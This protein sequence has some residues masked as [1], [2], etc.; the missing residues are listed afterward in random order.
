MS[1]PSVEPGSPRNEVARGEGPESARNVVAWREGV[2]G[3]GPEHKL[4]G[5]P[6]SGRVVTLIALFLS[7]AVHVLVIVLYPL[8]MERFV[9]TLEVVVRGVIQLQPRGIEIV[10]LVETPTDVAPS[11]PEPERPRPQP[12][13]VVSPATGPTTGEPGVTVGPATAPGPEAEREPTAADRLRPTLRDPRLWRPT[14]E[15]ITRLTEA[16]RMKIRLYVTLEALGD[17]MAAE[18]AAVAASTDWTVTD[19]EGNRWGVSPGQI[20]LGKITLP[21]PFGFA[22]D[23]A[24]MRR[25]REW[26]EIEGAASAAEA[27]AIREERAKAIRER[28]DR[29][30]EQRAAA[31]TTQGQRPPP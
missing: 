23:P 12:E 6:R 11:V 19:S 16:E 28:R 30:R 27:R 1:P 10:Q 21:L 7:V 2:P 15:A 31:D 29:E 18:A 3:R 22:Q 26:S 17:S 20:H 13:P 5:R 25:T 8:W 24:T 4:L 14:D 9:P